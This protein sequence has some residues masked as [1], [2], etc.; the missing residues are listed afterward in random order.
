MKIIKIF[1]IAFCI[2]RFGEGVVYAQQT[3]EGT[4]PNAPPG[5]ITTPISTTQINL[6]WHDNAS[7]EDGFYVYHNGVLIS[8]I[9]NANVVSYTDV[10]LLCP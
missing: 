6:A 10:G 1:F 4:P 5:L 8:T 2:I 9:T 3:I 7:D